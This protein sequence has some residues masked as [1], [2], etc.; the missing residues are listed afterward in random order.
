MLAR[1]GR[2]YRVSVTTRLYSDTI[3]ITE[4]TCFANT[5]SGP[6]V[7]PSLQE[8]GT[9]DGQESIEVLLTNLE[10]FW[11]LGVEMVME[12]EE[13]VEKEVDNFEVVVVTPRAPCGS[14]QTGR[15]GPRRRCS[16]RWLLPTSAICNDLQT[17]LFSQSA[18][19]KSQSF[20]N[21]NNKICFIV[22]GLTVKKLITKLG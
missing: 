9:G 17:E 11:L 20:K 15:S 18:P 8:F 10:G 1:V 19:N 6:L 21:C 4:L 3:E 16:H 5:P 2:E 22:K 14:S 7:T 13:V 12:E